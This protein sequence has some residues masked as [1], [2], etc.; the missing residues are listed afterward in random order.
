MPHRFLALLAGL[1]GA[2][3]TPLG[4][5]QPPDYALLI[6]ARERLQLATPCEIGLYLHERLAARLHQGQSAA[7]NLPPGEVSL[8][9]ATLGGADCQ[10]GILT[11]LRQRLSLQAGQVRRYR[12][13][14]G[15]SG[16]YLLP[17][18]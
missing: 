7:F 12:I 8:R 17:A 13:A 18:P 6:V 9:L 4:L 14:Q 15:D 5:A 2:A 16:L 3:A 11:P 10:P 1:L